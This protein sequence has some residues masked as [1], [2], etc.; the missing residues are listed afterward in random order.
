MSCLLVRRIILSATR[1]QLHFAAPFH[2]SIG[3][4][5]NK[6]TSSIVLNDL[7]L[8]ET[9]IHGWGPGGQ[10]IN[11]T[12]N[13]VRL[14]HLPT[15]IYVKCQDSRD[16]QVNRLIAR[17]RLEERLDE[18]LNG[19]SSASAVRRREAQARENNRFSR[20]KRRL[21]MKAAFK[22]KCLKGGKSSD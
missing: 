2:A 16:L 10:A 15:G 14:K 21:E 13:C 22:T 11:K 3:R 5:S 6:E 17:R 8:E 12:A 20:A 4:C 18:I 1:L 19:E 7:D 9:F